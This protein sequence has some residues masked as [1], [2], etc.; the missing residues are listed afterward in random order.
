MEPPRHLRCEIELPLD[1]EIIEPSHV[2]VELENISRADAPSEVVAS[3]QLY[4][5]ELRGGDLISL[6][7]EVPMDA[8]DQ[9]HLYSVRVHVDMTGS[10]EVERGDFITMQSFPVLTRGYGDNVRV[11]VRKV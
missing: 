3:L 8:L 9:R 1:E 7:L 5:G 6:E 4:P 2:L 10:G 11:T